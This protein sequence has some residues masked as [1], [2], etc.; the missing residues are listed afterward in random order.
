M[1]IIFALANFNL[2]ILIASGGPLL[3]IYKHSWT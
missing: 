2:A 1:A 3:Q